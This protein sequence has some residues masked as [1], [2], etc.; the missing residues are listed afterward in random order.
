MFKSGFDSMVFAKEFIPLEKY[1][2]E[3]DESALNKKPIPTILKALVGASVTTQEADFD[4]HYQAVLKS[5]F[6]KY[7]IRQEKP[8]YKGAHI[9]KQI[10]AKFDEAFTD[11]LNGIGSAIAH[12]DLYFATYPKPYVAIFGKGQ[13]Q[14]LTPLEYIEKH[15][16]G[17]AHACAWWHWRN[18]SN[19]EQEYEYS[20]D[21]FESKATPAWAE[22]EK[23]K[24]NMKVYYSGCECNC[25]ISFADLLLK[26]IELFHF[27]I[28]DYRSIAQ[29]I[30]KRCNTLPLTQKIKCFNLSKFDWVMKATVPE[31]PL[32]I[33]LN[34]YIKHP[35]YFVAWTP[36][37]PRKT[38]K[39]SFEWSKLYTSIVRKA[40]ETKGCLKFLDFDK[41]M[42]FWEDNDFIIPWE[43]ADEE[44]VRLLTSMKFDKMPKILKPSEL[45][46]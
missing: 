15:Q 39:T 35:I 21:H 14:R 8:I 10:G 5:V 36:S 30:W 18:F 23:N 17:F 34:G 40:I 12:V 1:L 11:I 3:P 45:I 41:D 22:M 37:L 24:V 46:T 7:G 6:E 27:G 31:S 28:I 13:G 19:A 26:T 16:N 4:E 33:N 20:I 32:D 42:T 29:P 38:V 43:T 25:L 2:G 9:I 44:H